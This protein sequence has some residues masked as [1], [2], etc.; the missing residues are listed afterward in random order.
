MK[1]LGVN[2]FKSKYNVPKDIDKRISKL[3][4]KIDSNNTYIDILEKI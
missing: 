2:V 1:I 4:L 3:K